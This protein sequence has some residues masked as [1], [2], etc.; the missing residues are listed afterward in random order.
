MLLLRSYNSAKFS[1]KNK[2]M[3]F[4]IAEKK[5]YFAQFS[6]VLYSLLICG[7][8]TLSYMRTSFHVIGFVFLY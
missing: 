6:N 2:V 7:N 3:S 5:N 1:L 4:A 8:Y